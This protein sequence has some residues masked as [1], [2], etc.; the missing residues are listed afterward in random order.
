[1]RL[2]LYLDAAIIDE[3]ER[4]AILYQKTNSQIARGLIQAGS[5]VIDDGGIRIRGP[6]L[7]LDRPFLEIRYRQLAGA[8]RRFGLRAGS[9]DAVISARRKPWETTSGCA[10]HLLELGLIT[11]NPDAFEL[12]GPLQLTRPLAH[13]DIPNVNV[14]SLLRNA[15]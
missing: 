1:M 13:T 2:S 8:K 10:I 6:L 7:G 9:T 3:I 11:S 4:L 15:S 5:R 12:V 14:E